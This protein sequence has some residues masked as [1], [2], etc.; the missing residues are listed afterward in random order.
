[1]SYLTL[2]RPQ[3][4]FF[5]EFYD[6]FTPSIFQPSR[7]LTQKRYLDPFE[8]LFSTIDDDFFHQKSIEND[9]PFEVKMKFSK[10]IPKE[11]IQIE[12]ENGVL[13]IK[14]EHKNGNSFES[15]SKKVT[16][17]S[18]INLEKI[19]A[20]LNNGQLQISIPKI[21]NNLIEENKETANEEMKNNVNEKNKEITNEEME[22][23]RMEEELIIEDVNQEE[24]DSI[25][26]TK[27]LLENNDKF[28]IED[29]EIYGE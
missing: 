17:P 1:M 24:E 12:V 28:I 10:K 21:E 3:R 5:N 2:R 9:K 6:D 25:D 14:A 19:S 11:N 8:E 29:E 27:P 13:T 4:S 15:Y 20:K 23:E 22:D 16:I 26:E 7:I 18:N